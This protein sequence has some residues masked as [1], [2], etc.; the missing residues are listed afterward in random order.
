MTSSQEQF[1]RLLPLA[2]QWARKQEDY[3]LAKGASL[4]PRHVADAARAGVQYCAR[5][6]VLV[7]DRIPLPDNEELAT[8]ARRA[9]IITEASRAITLGYGIVVR[10]DCWDDRELLLHQFVHVAQY[11]RC[12][13][14]E[15]CLE[16]YLIDRLK[17]PDF[18]TGSL[19]EE[20]R[21]DAR[22]ICAEDAAGK[23]IE[24]RPMH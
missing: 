15:T 20:A 22:R 12:A 6:R 5:V 19:E 17:C 23:Q 18:S 10:A 7:V 21:R 11:E 13:D 3:I 24:S 9:H 14:L 1:E 4:G 16:Q 2:F 8:I